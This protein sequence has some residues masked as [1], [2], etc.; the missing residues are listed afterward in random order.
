MKK[1]LTAIIAVTALASMFFLGQAEAQSIS[2]R[3][4]FRLVVSTEALATGL[5]G[6]TIEMTAPEE[7]DV[8]CGLGL[9]AVETCTQ[10]SVAQ[11]SFADTDDLIKA[12]DI[13]D[14]LAAFDFV[15]A[16]GTYNV[17]INILAADDEAGDPLVFSPIS[18]T[19]TLP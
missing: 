16:P 5:T 9:R 18:T 7:I 8:D 14:S 1:L 2:V 17:Q 13:V 4:I 15:G 10:P 19:I 12:G 11:Y 3:P 6:M